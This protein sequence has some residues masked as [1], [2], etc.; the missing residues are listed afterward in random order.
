[1]N[2]PIYIP[3]ITKLDIFLLIFSFVP[4]IN[5]KNDVT[6]NKKLACKNQKKGIGIISPYK[7]LL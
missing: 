7:K 1:M 6:N 2:N 3:Q 4:T 5:I